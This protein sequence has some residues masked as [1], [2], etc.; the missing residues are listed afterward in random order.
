MMKF[1]LGYLHSRSGRKWA[2]RVTEAQTT[3]DLW[4]LFEKRV[5]PIVREYFRG[6]ADGEIT[7]KGNVRAFQQ[8]MTTAHGAIKADSLD[9]RTTVVNHELQVPWFV[10]PVG[11]LR[12]VWPKAETIAAK[13]AGECGTICGF[14]L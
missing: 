5:P 14:P 10:A 7:L 11:S 4:N 13:V 9:L 12:S 2:K 8:A 1:L 6:A 3:E